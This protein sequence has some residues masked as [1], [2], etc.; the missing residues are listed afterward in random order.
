MKKKSLKN[1]AIKKT[2]VS[3][4]SGGAT[5]APQQGVLSIGKDCTQPPKCETARNCSNG[6]FCDDHNC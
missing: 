5:D 1:L 3:K 6:V 2:T 4:M